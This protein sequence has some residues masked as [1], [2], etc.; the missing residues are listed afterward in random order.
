MDVPWMLSPWLLPAFQETFHGH[1]HPLGKSRA[2]Q[3]EGR[4]L[5]VS[6]LWLALLQNNITRVSFFK[7][8]K[9]NTHPS[10]LW[11][12]VPHWRRSSQVLK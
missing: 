11:S 6:Q 4:A 3:C 7:E 5:E 10:D 2:L 12:P 1:T 8:F 9:T